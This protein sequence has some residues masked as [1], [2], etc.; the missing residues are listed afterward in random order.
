MGTE[1]IGIFGVPTASPCGAPGPPGPASRSPGGAKLGDF[2]YSWKC[3]YSLGKTPLCEPRAIL[4]NPPWSLLGFL[5]MWISLFRNAFFRFLHPADRRRA[6]RAPRPQK[7]IK[8]VPSG[9]PVASQEVPGGPEET[10]GGPTAAPCRPPAGPSLQSP[11]G[12][13]QVPCR[14]PAVPG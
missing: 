3:H 2:V 8:M 5:G 10:P 14:L 1:H 13:L 9:T 6:Q 11:A 4:G 12:P 7:V